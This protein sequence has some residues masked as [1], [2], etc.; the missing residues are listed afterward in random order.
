MSLKKDNQNKLHDNKGATSSEHYNTERRGN[1]EK[2]YG[3]SKATM[4][5]RYKVM[6]YSLFT[7]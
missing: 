3:F 7:H 2:L 5:C 6:S 4:F 1:C